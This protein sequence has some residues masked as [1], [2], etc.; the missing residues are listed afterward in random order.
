M[1]ELRFLE[2]ALVA[3]TMNQGVVEDVPLDAFEDTDCRDIYEACIALS[4]SGKPVNIL[5]VS[6]HL[7]EAGSGISV[8]DLAF[9]SEPVETLATSTL[10]LAEAVREAHRGRESQKLGM[11]LAQGKMTRLAALEGL[12]QLAE[13]GSAMSIAKIDDVAQVATARLNAAV[14]ASRKGQ[15]LPGELRSGF[16]ILDSYTIF[17][18]GDMVVIAAR[19]SQGK[20]SLARTILR[21]VAERSPVLLFT[22]EMSP[23][24][25]FA[26]LVSTEA[27]IDSLRVRRGLLT[28]EEVVTY[29]YY[30]KRLATMPITIQR[31]GDY[32]SIKATMKAW[33]RYHTDE[34]KP[35]MVIVDYV[36]QVRITGYRQNRNL[37]LN[38]VS[39][40][41][42]AAAKRLD[43]CL[44]CMA[45]MSRDVERR[46]GDRK[47]QL[48]DLRDSGAFEQDADSVLFIHRPA[49][50]DETETP[51]GEAAVYK[52]HHGQVVAHRTGLYIRKNRN[53]PTGMVEMLFYPATTKFEPYT[54]FAVEAIVGPRHTPFGPTP[55]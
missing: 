2:S 43:F 32:H 3:R 54:D 16:P 12:E 25:M 7:R 35:A 29:D 15:P 51:D 55:F 17:Q 8:T 13:G 49:Q 47:P 21:A 28:D 26:L 5:S 6:R 14:E 34:S 52:D 39:N 46:G 44:V 27:G 22:Q 33:R 4:D 36:Q 37:E 23:S 10:A 1:K 40:G 24:Q 50:Y 31:M 53:G 38:E 41:F 30:S 48:S 45:Q 18:S 20:S 42:Q 9:Y 11:S 19:P